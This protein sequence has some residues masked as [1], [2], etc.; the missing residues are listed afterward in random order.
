[1]QQDN[2]GDARKVLPGTFLVRKIHA[3]FL[4]IPSLLL[5]L[6][7]NM[8][9]KLLQPHA[10]HRRIIPTISAPYLDFSPLK[11]VKSGYKSVFAAD[12]ES[13][14]LSISM[15]KKARSINWYYCKH[16]AP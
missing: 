3:C 13:Y 12:Q 10:G 9:T 1:M 4:Q 14:R 11:P 15:A 5:Q 16:F 6:N 7:P 2:N 8:T